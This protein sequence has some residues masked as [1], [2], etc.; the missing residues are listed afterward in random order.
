MNKIAVYSFFTNG[1]V[2]YMVPSKK[3]AEEQMEKTDGTQWDR[4]E[5]E[6][7]TG[8]VPIAWKKL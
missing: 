2:Y 8:G 1:L 6:L 7:V 5:R 4:I 3:A